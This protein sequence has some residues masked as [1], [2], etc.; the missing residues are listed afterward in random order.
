MAWFEN[1][2]W[3]GLVSLVN[4]NNIDWLTSGL[5]WYGM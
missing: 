2:L 4:W 5:V 1:R 3:F